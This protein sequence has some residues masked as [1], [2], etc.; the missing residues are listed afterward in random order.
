M[1]KCENLHSSEISVDENLLYKQALSSFENNWLNAEEE[2]VCI[3]S[4]RSQGGLYFSVI[5]GLSSHGVIGSVNVHCDKH[6][7]SADR[8]KFCEIV[9]RPEIVFKMNTDMVALSLQSERFM[10][11]FFNKFNEVT[12]NSYSC[13][14]TGKYKFEMYLPNLSAAITS[15]AIPD[16]PDGYRFGTLQDKH[17]EFIAKSWTQDLGVT[18]QKGDK[19]YEKYVK[20]NMSRPHVAVFH[21]NEEFPVGWMNVYSD[22][23]AGQLHVSPSHRRKGLA[24]L[25]VKQ[26][27]KTIKDARSFGPSISIAT[28]NY[29]SAKLFSSEGW[30][31]QNRSYKMYL[32]KTL[33]NGKTDNDP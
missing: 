31:K 32:F 22:G 11:T 29:T 15:P 26:M 25:I 4:Y 10:D 12:D 5:F 24:R 1:K 7:D 17:G 20:L 33:V 21:K 14:S 8:T 23:T 18:P 27:Y 6:S 3:E 28:E 13:T 19:K 16:L 30:V 2:V 9:F